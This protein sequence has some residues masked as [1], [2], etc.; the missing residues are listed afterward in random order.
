MVRRGLSAVIV[1]LL[2][3]A[4][5]VLVGATAAEAAVPTYVV[6]SQIA[7]PAPGS[8]VAVDPSRAL[9][10]VASRSTNEVFVFDEATLTLQAT[11][12]VPNQPYNITVGPTGVVY[13][14]QYTGNFLPGTVA[15]ID[16]VSR[17]VVATSRSGT[18]RS[19]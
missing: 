12:P 4:G 17:T 3:S 1:G 2:V 9:V 16:P 8:G 5:L 18:L 10:Y 7:L 19:G 11:I 13:V 14:S 15:V 6:K